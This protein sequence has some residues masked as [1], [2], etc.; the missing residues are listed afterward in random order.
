MAAMPVRSEPC[1]QCTKI[2]GSAR[3][4]TS[5]RHA[6]L[7]ARGQMH[8]RERHVF[9]IDAEP[10]ARL[11]FIDVPFV[12]P[13][14]AAHIQH[15]ANLVALNDSFERFGRGLGAA[16]ELARNDF[17]EIADEHDPADFPGGPQQERSGPQEKPAPSTVGVGVGSADRRFRS[18]APRKQNRSWASLL[19]GAFTSMSSGGIL[20]KLP[21]RG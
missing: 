21:V 17:V 13:A 14:A 9:E 20:P 18:S 7:V 11:G 5:I 8:R 12:R 15:G 6:H 4:S 3:S 1:R 19:E 10:L 2:G 16:I